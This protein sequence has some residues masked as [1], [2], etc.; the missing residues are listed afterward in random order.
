[1]ITAYSRLEYMI[2]TSNGFKYSN[3]EVTQTPDVS[4]K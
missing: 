4:K 1:M 2:A 3:Q